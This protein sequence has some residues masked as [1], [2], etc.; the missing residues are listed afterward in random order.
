MLASS[1]DTVARR[2]VKPLVRRDFAAR[3]PANDRGPVWQAVLLI[4]PLDVARIAD[5]GS[6]EWKAAVTEHVISAMAVAVYMVSAP[7]ES[8]FWYVHKMAVAATHAENKFAMPFGAGSDD[9]LKY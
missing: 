3:P 4:R 9:Y 6:V 1:I 5:D 8:F 7:C 2:E